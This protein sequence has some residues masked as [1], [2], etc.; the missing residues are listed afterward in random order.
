MAVPARETDGVGPPK[1]ASTA[2]VHLQA[3]PTLGAYQIQPGLT[4]MANSTSLLEFPSGSGARRARAPISVRGAVAVGLRR[5]GRMVAPLWGTVVFVASLLSIVLIAADLKSM[6]ASISSV[7][8]SLPIVFGLSHAQASLVTA[9][10]EAMMGLVAV[11]APWLARRFGRDRVILAAL[12]LLLSATGARVLAGSPGAILISTAGIT[13]GIVLAGTVIGGLTSTSSQERNVLVTGAYVAAPTLGAAL[14][15]HGVNV[16]A[17]SGAAWLVSAGTWALLGPITIA[18]WLF[19]ERRRRLAAASAP[20]GVS[21][22]VLPIRERRAWLVAAFFAASNFLFSGLASWLTPFYQERGWGAAF[23]GAVL[24]SFVSIFLIANPI[25]ALLGRR[26]RPQRLRIA[27]SATALLGL[28]LLAFAK[29][30][31][32]PFLAP[33]IGAGVGGAFALGMTLPRDH[34][35]GTDEAG[36]WNAFVV[37]VACLVASLG[38]IVIGAVRDVTGGFGAGLWLL[39]GVAAVMLALAPWLEPP[40]APKA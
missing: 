6:L 1:G 12:V 23:A 32:P 28:V 8:P 35:K 14:A 21:R 15:G 20:G 19:V 18:A 3:R 16:V 40:S 13:A 2:S 4:S 30:Q 5:T 24:V 31:A 26:V 27:F 34:A 38:P 7:L 11:P 25:V 36:A 33:L 39:A 22:F 29:N 10:P 37:M 9:A 17:P